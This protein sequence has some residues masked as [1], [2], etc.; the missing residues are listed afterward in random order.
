MQCFKLRNAINE[1]SNKA[2]TYLLYYRPSAEN[3]HDLPSIQYETTRSPNKMVS[4]DKSR[5]SFNLV[6]P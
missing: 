3:K 5:T 4:E 2:L 6:V 1:F